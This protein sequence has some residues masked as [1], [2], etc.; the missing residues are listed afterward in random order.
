MDDDWKFIASLFPEISFDKCKY[1]W[2][3][4]QK[5]SIQKD[6]WLGEEDQLLKN[7]VGLV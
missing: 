5:S 3:T 6:D 4:L 1:K 7:L 2:Y